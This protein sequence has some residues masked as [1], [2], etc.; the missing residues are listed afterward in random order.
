MDILIGLTN[1]CEADILRKSYYPFMVIKSFQISR[2]NIF[3]S[4]RISTQANIK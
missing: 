3:L 4:V 2:Q 1:I